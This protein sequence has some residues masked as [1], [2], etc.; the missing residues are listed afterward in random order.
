MP[1]LCQRRVR[2]QALHLN[3]KGHP[4]AV[5]RIPP[6]KDR[7][8]VARTGDGLRKT[9]NGNSY[10]VHQTGRKVSGAQSW[11]PTS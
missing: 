1:Y 7:L 2:A 8:M 5:T 11:T 3:R 10:A 4:S 6:F 9:L